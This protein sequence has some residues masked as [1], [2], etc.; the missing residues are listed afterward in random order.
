MHHHRLPQTLQYRVLNYLEYLWGT[1]K[2]LDE[3]RVASR[4]PHSA[5]PQL[6]VCG[7]QVDIV[8]R[9]PETLQRSVSLFTNDQIIRATPL[10]K[11]CSAEVSAYVVRML[12]LNVFVPGDV[13]FSRGDES[14]E[15]FIMQRGLVEVCS[16]PRR[17]A[18][19]G[20]L[21]LEP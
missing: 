13:L 15:L 3:V 4:F 2:G 1:T 17:E 9:L 10:F 18:Q 11:G 6:P 14:R 20:P 5:P 16:A 7:H 12:Q 19:A 21:S 8:S